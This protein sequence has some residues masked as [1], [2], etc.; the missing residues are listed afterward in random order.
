M[1]R[2]GVGQQQQNKCLVRGEDGR[3]PHLSHQVGAQTRDGILAHGIQQECCRVC[4]RTGKACQPVAPLGVL[5]PGPTGHR[6]EGAPTVG[7]S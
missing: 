1:R 4:Q 6:Q 7:N 2:G 3:Q 5:E